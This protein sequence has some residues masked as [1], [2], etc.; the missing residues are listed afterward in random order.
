[1]YKDQALSVRK[2]VKAQPRLFASTLDELTK[3]KKY[4]TS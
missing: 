3:D 4:L 1:V 2:K